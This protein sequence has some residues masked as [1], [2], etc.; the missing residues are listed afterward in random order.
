MIKK[1]LKRDN[2]IENYKK[3]K[4]VSAIAKAANEIGVKNYNQIAADLAFDIEERLSEE[5]GEIIPSVEDIQDIV[6]DMLI[7][8]NYNKIAKAYIKYRE[9]MRKEREEGWF[10]LELGK[11]AWQRKYQYNGETFEEFTKRVSGGKK[12]YARAIRRKEFCPAG[13]VLANRGVPFEEVKSSYA[14]CYNTPINEDSLEGIFQA[15]Y[16]ISKTF[17]YGGGSGIDF[18]TLRPRGARV[19]NAA[20]STTG[21]VSF[22]A[23][24]NIIGEI[25]G[26]ASRRSATIATLKVSHPDIEEFIEIKQDLKKVNKAN[27]SVRITDEFMEK[28]LN[29]EEFELSFYVNSTGEEI[30]KTV[31]ATKIFNKLAYTNYDYAEPGVLFWD[32]IENWNIMTAHDGYNLTG[33]NPCGERPLTDYGACALS[34]VNLSKIV[35]NPFSPNAKINYNKLKNFTALGVKYL[36][37]VLD[38][39]LSRHPLPKQ[40]E[41][42]KKFREIGLGIMGFSD[43]LIKLGIKYGSSKSK[44][45]ASKISNVMF[46]TALQ[47]SALLAKEN[48][49]FP[50]YSDI[51]L[52][53]PIMQHQ[54]SLDTKSLIKKYGLRNSSL[55]SIA[56]TGTISNIFGVAGGFEP[57]FDISYERKT[58]SFNENYKVFTPVVRELMDFYNLKPDDKLPNYVVTA[59]DINYKDKIDVQANLQKNIDSSISNT[60]NLPKEA[61]IEDVRK[62]YIYGW[63]KGLKGMTVYR[64]G[65]ARAGI[66]TNSNSADIKTA[67]TMDFV[68]NNICPECNDSLVESGGCKSCRSCGYSPCSV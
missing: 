5:F 65:C 4:I 11:S 13:R 24:F 25:V 22:L 48:G 6:E 26:Q 1:V 19:N 39:G 49:T 52:E 46:N 59:H 31:Q 57:I 54:I 23:I 62:A 37:E 47:T 28:V 36:N 18:S 44:I 17:A 9:E 21:A 15:A 61:T 45:L 29:D 7:E 43:L 16:E 8:K 56:P 2:N 35:D 42:A 55:L 34:S 33:I 53:S 10:D 64:N 41:Q 60:L 68:S 63:K 20:K 67:D 30:K 12:H 51:I 50:E 40:T 27:L 66:L 58:E 38:E 32:R 3:E 14:N